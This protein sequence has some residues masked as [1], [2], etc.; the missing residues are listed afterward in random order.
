MNFFRTFFIFVLLLA[1]N[2]SHSRFSFEL[3]DRFRVLG[4]RGIKN[5]IK[6]T[7][8]VKGNVV[9]IN[10]PFT[11]YGGGSLL[12]FK[13][14]TI[15]VWDNIRL[16]S[17]EF[18]ILAKK[19]FIDLDKSSF[20]LNNG[21]YESENRT[22][23]GEKIL[24]TKDGTIEVLNGNFSTCQDCEQDWAF[25]GEKITI[26]PNE[27]VR[28]NS[29]Y[30]MI[31][32]V[33]IFYLPY[34]VF[35]IKKERES[36]F[37]FP[38]LSL[39]TGDGVY[40]QL[41]YFL[42]IS[43]HTDLTISPG[44][45]GGFGFGNE[46]EFRSKYSKYDHL[47][48]R[49]FY[50]SK[51]RFDSEINNNHIIFLNNINYLNRNTKF[52]LYV[53]YLNSPELFRSFNQFLKK[54]ILNEYFGADARLSYRNDLIALDLGYHD[55]KNLLSSSSS[56]SDPSLIQMKPR[57][58]FNINPITLLN[59][60]NGGNVFVD[61]TSDVH[62]FTRSAPDEAVFRSYIRHRNQTNIF[63]HLSLANYL[64][65]NFRFNNFYSNYYLDNK[66]RGSRSG[67][68]LMVGVRES[69]YRD[70][71]KETQKV[72][73]K[74]IISDQYDLIQLPDIT[75]KV[76]NSSNGLEEFFSYYRHTIDF[77]LNFYSTIFYKMDNSDI[78]SQQ[79][80]SDYSPKVSL[81]NDLYDFMPGFEYQFG[82]IVTNQ[83]FPQQKTLFLEFNNTINKEVRSYKDND[84]K[85]F[86]LEK[87]ESIGHFNVSQGV[88]FSGE[89]SGDKTR[90]TRLGINWS[91]F[92][93]NDLK[94]NGD[95][96]YFY[97]TKSHLSTINL[98]GDLFNLNY[99]F[100]IVID[101]RSDNKNGFFSVGGNLTNQF[102]VKY[103]T[104]RDFSDSIRTEEVYK[105]R[106][107]P[108]GKCWFYEMTFQE[109][110]VESRYFFNFALNYNEK[111][112][113]E[114]LRVF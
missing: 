24:K 42:A 109:T 61:F 46:L 91:F 70:F 114:M 72:E 104:R 80:N 16:S 11:M 71:L 63:G 47:E 27:Y 85:S 31:R 20:I 94:I 36:G 95:E 89:Y 66:D 76:K 2:L 5:S 41:P 6:K 81:I 107:T 12:N 105:V 15:D 68:S 28:I 34:L 26:T 22:L 35:P 25:F 48:M 67:S 113:S 58:R 92:L 57:V 60:K 78:S 51:D 65:F 7:F 111:L 43:D 86:E 110:L 33:P 74:N 49:Q 9:I 1:S 82:N 21:R 38:K 73:S 88:Y 106:Y 29:A 8:E 87:S 84:K 101:D 44:V 53:N 59:K 56:G 75:K 108:N 40:F 19:V 77:K 93:N 97:D 45:F 50:L 98:S 13:D 23:Y 62:S 39:N 37:I 4:D 103:L 69:F 79:I 112:F 30:F 10:G 52:H 99:V 102:R 17:S 55:Y 54:R 3:G 64:N 90:L 18:T 100:G 14:R 96:F 32:D 83:L